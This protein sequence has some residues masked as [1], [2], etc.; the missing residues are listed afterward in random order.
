MLMVGPRIRCVLQHA[1]P[2]C[3]VVVPATRPQ[4]PTAFAN[5]GAD[6][7]EDLPVLLHLILIRMHLAFHS[8]D[9]GLTGP[10][11]GPV[12]A[13]SHG[14]GDAGKL[15]A[16]LPKDFN[17]CMFSPTSLAFSYSD[18]DRCRL[19]LEEH[20]RRA[21]NLSSLRTNDKKDIAW[22]LGDLA[23][24][25][26]EQNLED[27][28]LHFADLARQLAEDNG[29]NVEPVSMKTFQQPVACPGSTPHRRCHPLATPTAF[30]FPQLI[31]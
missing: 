20:V 5:G 18:S 11:S 26:W 7:L 22:T 13:P 2:A 23:M 27:S 31:L 29:L 30:P 15:Y 28:Q 8:S 14:R 17:S 3:H 12:W 25:V 19:A 16:P 10:W 1:S 21:L 4:R 6:V 9:T 24:W